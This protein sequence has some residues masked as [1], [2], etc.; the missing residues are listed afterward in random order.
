MFRVFT[1][2]A[3][4]LCTT[5]QRTYLSAD[6]VAD[7][8]Y[9]LLN[10]VFGGVAYE[11]PDCVHPIPHI[12][13]QFDDELQTPVFVFYSHIDLDN[14]RCMVFDRVRTEIKTCTESSALERILWRLCV[15]F[16]GC[17]IRLGSPTF[18][19]LLPC[20]PDQACWWS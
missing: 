3:V 2:L 16:L 6:G 17:A 7:D 19:K 15:A 12:S 4:C 18:N 8:T 9:N 20:V 14:D 13:Q 11:V 5:G 1:L 10:R